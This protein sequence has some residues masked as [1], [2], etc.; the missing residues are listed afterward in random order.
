MH[1]HICEN[2]IEKIER[3]WKIVLLTEY[4]K[5]HYNFHIL[6]NFSYYVHSV[7]VYSFKFPIN[8]KNPQSTYQFRVSLRTLP[9]HLTPVECFPAIATLAKKLPS[10]SL[11]PIRA[12]SAKSL[13]TTS[14][15]IP[16]EETA[17]GIPVRHLPPGSPGSV[18]D[19]FLD[20]SL[21][22]ELD[23]VYSALAMGL[24]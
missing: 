24:N 3:W 1:I 5:K 8:A 6:H 10:C 19:E 21:K 14:R 13:A 16:K 20:R 18:V 17:D 22:K 23:C 9:I 4:Y 2:E 11:N 7:Y 15:S 12:H